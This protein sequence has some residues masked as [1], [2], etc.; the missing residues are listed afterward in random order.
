MKTD[1][2]FKQRGYL[3]NLARLRAIQLA[4]L[5][6]KTLSD[7]QRVELEEE[8]AFAETLAAVLDAG[9]DIVVDRPTPAVVTLRRDID[10]VG[11]TGS[12]GAQPRP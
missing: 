8:F 9:E 1:L 6:K 3:A 10:A 7:S 11:S 5:S 2:D 12:G 4:K